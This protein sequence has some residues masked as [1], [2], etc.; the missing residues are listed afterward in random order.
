MAR[1][2]PDG[3]ASL[4]LLNWVDLETEPEEMI[5]KFHSFSRHLLQMEKKL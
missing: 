5:S 2:A 1:N 4:V 3:H